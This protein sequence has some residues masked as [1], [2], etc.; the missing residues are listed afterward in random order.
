MQKLPRPT[1]LACTLFQSFLTQGNNL[2]ESLMHFPYMT[3]IESLYPS[4]L[5]WIDANAEILNLQ[6][7]DVLI[8]EGSSN[9][10]LYI[11]ES[12]LLSVYT[13]GANL[14]DMR[15]EIA[16]IGSGSLVGDLSWLETQV[17]SASVCALENSVLLRL[18]GEALAAQIAADS[19]FAAR[20]LHGI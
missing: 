14:G 7:D 3:F 13:G 6:P 11:L 9:S 8:R 12:G 5:G 4:D 16:R 15:H 20:F 2:P 10:D 19:E 18:V 17:P 1:R